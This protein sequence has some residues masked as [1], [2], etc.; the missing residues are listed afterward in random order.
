MDIV[1]T[2]LVSSVVWGPLGGW[3]YY[4]YGATLKHEAVK[5]EQL[6]AEKIAKL[7]AAGAIVEAKAK[8]LL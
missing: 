2:F 4:Q 1:V 3:L 7:R 6:L 5:A 8:G